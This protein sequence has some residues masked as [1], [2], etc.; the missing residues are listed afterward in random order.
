MSN[1]G[2]IPFTALG[3]SNMLVSRLERS[4]PFRQ[5]CRRRAP[6]LQARPPPG[7]ITVKFRIACFV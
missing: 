3:V 1:A 7:R 5:I 4:R 2:R 6:E